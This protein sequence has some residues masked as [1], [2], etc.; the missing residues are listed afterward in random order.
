MEI[1]KRKRFLSVLFICAS[2][3][4]LAATAQNESATIVN[5]GSTN[6]M[7]YTITLWTDGTGS[8]QIR[9]STPAAFTIPKATAAQFFS[10]LKAARSN[11][12]Q[13]Q[14]C[15][16]SA[17]FGSSTVVQWNGWNSPDLQCPPFTTPVATLAQDVSGVERAAGI[18]SGA[19]MHRVPL[20]PGQV[21]KIP[22]PTPEV[23]PT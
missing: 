11:G 14:H 23:Q 5:S 4:V 21:R 6:T 16:K 3:T 10:D 20:L 17:S 12:E 9:G 1:R 15:M 7:S 22:T 18:Q 2:F 13:L 8:T 19:L